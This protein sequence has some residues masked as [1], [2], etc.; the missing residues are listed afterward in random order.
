MKLCF[1]ERLRNWETRERRK[2]KEHNKE[3]EKDKKQAD[4]M[5]KEGRRLKEFLED[6][7]DERDDPK[8]YK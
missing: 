1:Q 5:S 3:R 2:A 8:F 6:Y 4:E 7:D